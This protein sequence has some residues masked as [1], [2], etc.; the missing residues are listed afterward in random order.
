LDMVALR[1]EPPPELHRD[2]A[3]AA[4]YLLGLAARVYF[5]E[6]GSLDPYVQLALGGA[7]LA[8]A[9]EEGSGTDQQRYE[10]TGAGPALQFGAGVD[11]Y[12]TPLLRLGPALNSTLVFVDKIRRCHGGG[13]GECVDVAKGAHGH[14]DAYATIGARLTIS[15]GD[16]L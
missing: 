6:E 13:E 5:A 10:E 15:L 1:Y 16:E 12:L 9:F 8:T 14:V 11:F 3:G 4:A 7:A 2:R